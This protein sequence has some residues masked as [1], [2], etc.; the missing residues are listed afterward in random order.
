LLGI[1]AK[2]TEDEQW[3]F[4]TALLYYDESDSRVTVTEGIIAAKK[5]FDYGHFLD[6]K[7]TLDSLTGASPTGAVPQ[8]AVQTFTRP[9]GRGSYQVNAEETPL[10]DTF[11]DTR[12]QLN[13]QW[14][15]PWAEHYNISSGLHL[16]KE[17]DYTSIGFNS[18]IA[19]DL[20]NKNTTISAGLSYANDTIAP[21]G[22]RPMPL[23]SVVTTTA[24]NNSGE[25][26]DGYHQA[27]AL[28]R[29]KGDGK[30]Q[31][32]DLLFGL[33]QVIN[34]RML[35]QFNYSFSNSN[36]YQTDPFK[37][38]SVVNSQGLSQD[39]LYESRP[40]KRNKHSVYWQT[41]YHFTQVILDASYRYMR[42]D[43]S[44]DSHTLDTR[45]RYPLSDNLYIEPHIRYY[46]QTS[47]EFYYPFLNSIEPQLKYATADYRLGALN[48]YT[49]GAKVGLSLPS[50]KKMSVRLE[51]YTQKPDTGDIERPGVLGDYRLNPQV[52]A[53]IMQL[54]LSF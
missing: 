42:D 7:V 50:G 6:L 14:T 8:P 19:K 33:T 13:G 46:R 28:T 29:Q 18:S 52:N 1:E 4:D 2:A 25:Y 39:H 44:L 47:V 53:I 9:S 16:S 17:Y 5:T 35:M 15:Q 22:G 26:N 37:M 34:R 12:L 49:L 38:L 36:G 48:T 40:D 54:G 3:Q 23:V 27:H 41:K 32:L 43:W 24:P 21:E 10:D 51:Y 31:T 20:N 11:K 45:I 30:K